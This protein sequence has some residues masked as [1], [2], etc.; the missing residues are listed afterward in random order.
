[1]PTNV[2]N[3]MLEIE[4]KDERTQSYNKIQCKCYSKFQVRD[5]ALWPKAAS[6]DVN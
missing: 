3:K 5:L 6:E 2:T 1:M 4:A